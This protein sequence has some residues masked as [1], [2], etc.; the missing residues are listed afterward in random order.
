MKLESNENSQ[1]FETLLCYASI[2]SF[3]QRTGALGTCSFST[4]LITALYH[5]SFL[6]D[7]FFSN[8][9]ILF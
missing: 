8:I 9:Q 5:S 1:Q 4:S 7:S 3:F 2:Y 6:L